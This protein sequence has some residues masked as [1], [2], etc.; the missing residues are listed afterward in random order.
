MYRHEKTF[1]LDFIL[2]G[3]NIL[4]ILFNIIPEV[5][6]VWLIIWS[7]LCGLRLVILIIHQIK[8]HKIY[9]LET[10]QLKQMMKNKRED[11]E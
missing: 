9:Q 3:C 7:I 8:W 11:D 6:L 2:L 10:E 4:L 5:K 1:L